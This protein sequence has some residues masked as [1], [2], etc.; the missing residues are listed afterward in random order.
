M[1][2]TDLDG[3]QAEYKRTADLWVGSI[4]AEEALATPDHTMTAMGSWDTAGL[5]LH[6][7][8][9]RAKKARDEYKN[10]LRRKNYGF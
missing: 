10:A 2:D 8:E 1:S 5:A 3:L 4:R 9:L 6:D 7:A